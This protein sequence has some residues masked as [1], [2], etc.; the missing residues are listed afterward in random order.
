MSEFTNES[1][2]AIETTLG[3]VERALGRLQS[4]SYRQCQVCGT[5]ID[6]AALLNNPTVANCAAHRELL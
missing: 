1:V 2:G 3:K 4:G 5:E 6:P